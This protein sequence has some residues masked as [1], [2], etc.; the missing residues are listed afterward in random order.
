MFADACCQQILVFY[1]GKQF[2][3]SC[4]SN[5]DII[6]GYFMSRLSV[7]YTDQNDCERIC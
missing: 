5:K 6:R 3:H 4:V 7:Y 1:D 2:P